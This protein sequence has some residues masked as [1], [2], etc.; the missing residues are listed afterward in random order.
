MYRSEIKKKKLIFS[1]N[2][3][4]AGHYTRLVNEVL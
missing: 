4:A 3:H 1:E 2:S